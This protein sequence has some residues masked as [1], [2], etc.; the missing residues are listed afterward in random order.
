[1]R[2]AVHS[3]ASSAGNPWLSLCSTQRQRPV[4]PAHVVGPRCD[5]AER[6]PTHDE[7]TVAEAFQAAGY[8]TACFGKWHNGS[9]W[10]Y[11]PMARGFDEYY[12]I[13]RTSNEAQTG[14]AQIDAAV[15]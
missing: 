4:L 7:A 10:P 12:G 8:A 1:M 13:P 2:R 14:I 6:R 3:G 9:Q 5:H 15:R 11:H